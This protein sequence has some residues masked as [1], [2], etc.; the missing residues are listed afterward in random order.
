MWLK[1]SILPKAS[2]GLIQSL[3]K[4][5]FFF[6]ELEQIILKFVW[7]HKRPQIGKAILRKKNKAG[8]ITIPY[9]KI[10]YKA[11]VMKTVWY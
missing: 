1:M 4:Y 11:I 3:S 7:N 9:F 2:V 8:S 10:Y 6:T 5:Q